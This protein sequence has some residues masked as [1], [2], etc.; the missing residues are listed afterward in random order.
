MKIVHQRVNMSG[1]AVE[2]YPIRVDFTKEESKKI[3]WTN[4][5]F[6]WGLATYGPFI[7]TWGVSAPSRRVENAYF[8]SES[9][10]M[11]YIL[12]WYNA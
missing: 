9:D 11:L 3:I 2:Q 4:E 8:F 6:E 7:K 1:R 5:M 10:A 12:R